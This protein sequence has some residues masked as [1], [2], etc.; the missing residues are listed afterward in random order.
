M[1]S[2]E[3]Q[4]ATVRRLEIIGE[5]VKNLEKSFKKKYPEVEW[6]KIAGMRNIIV[7]EYFGVDLKLTYKIVKASIPDLKNKISKILKEMK[8]NKLI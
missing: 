3:K 5:A 1:Q 8:A 4:D 7:H 2:E 6:A